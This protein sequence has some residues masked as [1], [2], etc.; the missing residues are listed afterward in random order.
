MRTALEQAG[1]QRGVLIVWRGGE[2]WCVAEGSTRN[3][4]IDVELCDRP[5]AEMLL[6]QAV[7]Q[8]VLHAREPVILDDAAAEHPFSADRYIRSGKPGPFSACR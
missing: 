3:D 2:L 1:A 4:A 7:V 8:Y 5:L 6:P